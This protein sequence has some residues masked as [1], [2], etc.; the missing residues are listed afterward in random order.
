MPTFYFDRYEKII[1]Y[2]KE[3]QLLDEV[4]NHIPLYERFL[5]LLY[6]EVRQKKIL[7][8]MPWLYK[9]I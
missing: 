9:K 3:E 7:P 6:F 2:H 4:L 1:D 8:D 5:A